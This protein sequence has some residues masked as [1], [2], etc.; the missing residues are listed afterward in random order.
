MG[1]VWSLIV[2]STDDA[3]HRGE[4]RVGDGVEDVS[5]MERQEGA[6][7][8]RGSVSKFRAKLVRLFVELENK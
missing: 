1:Q 7:A 2:F 4:V 6:G 5:W 8:G 3:R